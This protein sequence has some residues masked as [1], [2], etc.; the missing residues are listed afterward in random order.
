MECLCSE[1]FTQLYIMSK[2]HSGVPWEH[3][4]W[5]PPSP[6]GSMRKES[7]RFV[8]DHS[9]LTPNG[10]YE[11]QPPV[12]G[13]RQTFLRQ[14][15][16]I[17]PERLETGNFNPVHYFIPIVNKGKEQLI[18]ESENILKPA[19]ENDLK[20][21][22]IFGDPKTVEGQ[23]KGI[24]LVDHKILFQLRTYLFANLKAQGRF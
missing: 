2:M 12:R 21:L 8:P 18:M 16:I 14:S 24:K 1:G 5:W 13:Q 10:R 19:R 11:L 15:P 22:G 17:V 20:L 3:G 23:I 6:A 7:W 9:G 4:A